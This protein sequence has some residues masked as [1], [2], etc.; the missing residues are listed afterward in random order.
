MR[1]LL[2]KKEVKQIL[3]L[4][5]IAFIIYFIYHL[6]LYI[7]F[8][9]RIHY[10]ELYISDTYIT[11]PIA[12]EDSKTISWLVHKYVPDHN[13]GSEWMAHAINMY[14]I[15]NQS[16]YVNVLVNSSSVYEFERVH[17]IEDNNKEIDELMKDK[18]MD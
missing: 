1:N 11:E 17:I 9:Y 8:Y 7:R 15:G 2:K 10:A 6:I 4:L 18:D 16:Y 13:A 14:L 12:E 5:T 3:L